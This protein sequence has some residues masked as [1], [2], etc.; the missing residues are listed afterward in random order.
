[1]D[2]L[3]N[4]EKMREKLQEEIDRIDVFLLVKTE[5]SDSSL[6]QMRGQQQGFILA[7]NFIHQEIQRI[8]REE[9]KKWKNP[10]PTL[11]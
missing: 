2:E 8:S 5:L 11:T 6:A 1:M 4:G 9:S 10:Q 3:I 7:R